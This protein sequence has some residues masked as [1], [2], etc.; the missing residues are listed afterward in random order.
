[1]LAAAALLIAIIGS[2]VRF[3]VMYRPG[4]GGSTGTIPAAVAPS[5]AAGHD[6]TLLSIDIR[7]GALPNAERI[8]SAISYNILQPGKQ[9]TWKSACCTGLMV[10]YVT[11]GSY[12]VRP[13]APIRV[14]RAGGAEEEGAVGVE[15]TLAAGDALVTGVETD[16]HSAN[17]GTE[18]VG[19]LSFFFVDD[20]MYTFGGKAFPGWEQHGQDIAWIAPKLVGATRLT[21]RLVTAN[22]AETIAAPATGLQVGIPLPDQAGYTNDPPDGSSPIVSFDTAP[23]P[24]YVITLV[25][26]PGMDSTPAP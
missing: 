1:M 21:L 20:P 2:V 10:E 23:V 12:T 22:P 26:A 13:T 3:G 11:S 9:G 6:E 18:P 24:L 4:S 19:I 14:I 16:M 17:A 8:S 7:G 25:P 5:P 15:A